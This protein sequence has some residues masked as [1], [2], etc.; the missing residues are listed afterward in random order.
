MA[1]AKIRSLFET[2]SVYQ[3]AVVCDD[4]C[5]DHVLARLLEDG[6]PVARTLDAFLAFQDRML[7]VPRSSWNDEKLSILGPTVNMLIFINCQPDDGDTFAMRHAS[8][9]IFSL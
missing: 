6:Y 3:S 8:V 5:I 7:L 4:E 9:F 1:L 2:R